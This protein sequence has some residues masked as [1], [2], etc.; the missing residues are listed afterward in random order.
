MQLQGLLGGMV[1]QV[2]L[3]SRGCLLKPPSQQFVPLS[4]ADKSKG[5]H[6]LDESKKCTSAIAIIKKVLISMH[7]RYNYNNFSLIMF[8]KSILQLYKEF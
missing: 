2:F 7:L 4:E 5:T 6:V 3:A 1:E 8:G